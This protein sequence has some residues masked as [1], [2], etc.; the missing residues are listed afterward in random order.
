MQTARFARNG[1]MSRATREYREGV[2]D[3][4]RR[5]KHFPLEEI[6]A[7][8]LGTRPPG[9]KEWEGARDRARALPGGVMR[10]LCV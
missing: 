3:Y 10:A 7:C 5:W 6:A 9:E 2:S 4:E 8:R 1:E